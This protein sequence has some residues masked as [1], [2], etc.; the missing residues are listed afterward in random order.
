ME[1]S[2]DC[3][4]TDAIEGLK[5]IADNS[6]HLVLA[7]LPYGV[8][9]N[10]KDVVIP[11]DQ[12]WEQVKRIL[13]P[14]GVC[15]CYAQGLFYVD[16]V[17][18]NRK[19]FKY[20]IIWDKILTSGQLNAN[21]MPLRSHEQVAIFYDKQPVYNPQFTEG[22][23]LHSKG[24]SYKN[25]EPKNQNYGKFGV[26]DDTRAGSTSKYPK[27][28][29]SFPKPHPSKAI[30][31]TQK[32]AEMNEWI[33]K[34]F[35]NEGDLVVDPTAGSF[36]TGVACVTTGRSCILIEKDEMEYFKGSTRLFSNPFFRL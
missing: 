20:D 17:Q 22:K 34:T 27:S 2:I 12:F 31:A 4:H 9:Q 29:Q 3:W 14:N 1:L 6:V 35:T 36:T 8:T 7:D 13:T 32:S 21:R 33:I 30:H 24:T 19:M 18:S 23:P 16:L 5:K 28:I 11:F 26:T 10:K 15:A 25:K